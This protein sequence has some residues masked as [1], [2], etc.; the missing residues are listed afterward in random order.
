MS[1][2]SMPES[3]S[4]PFVAAPHASRYFPAA[5]FEESRQRITR[6]IERGEGPAILIGAT[7]TK[8]VVQIKKVFGLLFRKAFGSR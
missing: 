1:D 8:A 2:P 3:L 5:I 4:R 7:G 6:S